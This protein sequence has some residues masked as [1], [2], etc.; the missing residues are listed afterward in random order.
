[1]SDYFPEEVLIEILS[2]LPVKSLLR[3]TC[4]SKQWR[5]L[6]T[7]PSFINS[8]LNKSTNNTHTHLLLLRYTCLNPNQEHYSFRFDNKTFN[9]YAQ[10]TSPFKTTSISG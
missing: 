3:F 1:M 9:H 10:F 8:H 5:S 2:R 7:S 4:V 6:I